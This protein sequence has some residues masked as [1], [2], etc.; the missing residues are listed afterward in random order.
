MQEHLIIDGNNALHA[1]PVLAKSLERDR[2]LA[3]D[4]LIRM[5]EPLQARNQYLLTVVFD[6]RGGK[7]SLTKHQGNSNYSIIYSSSSQ[8][9]DGVIER[10]LMAAEF[11]ERITVGTNDNL[12]RNC[13]YTHGAA[14]MRVEELVKKLDNTIS[15]TRNL[16]GT[17]RKNEKKFENRIPFPD[18]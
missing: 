7:T 15:I 5:L 3:R 11:P 4:D 2:Q 18:D 1:I 14:V 17:P 12:I 16:S 9:A 8:G 6:G 10:M 13:A